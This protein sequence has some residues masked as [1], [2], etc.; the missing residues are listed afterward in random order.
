VVPGSTLYLFSDG[1][2]EVEVE[3]GKQQQIEDFVPLLLEPAGASEPERLVA[4]VRRRTGRKLFDDD[5]TVLVAT[6]A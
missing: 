4:E 6:F 5:L 3:G 1:V 2:F